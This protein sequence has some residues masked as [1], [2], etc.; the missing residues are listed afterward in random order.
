MKL[1]KILLISNAFLGTVSV[2]AMQNEE[3]IGCPT[4]KMVHPIPQPHPQPTWSP[5][6]NKVWAMEG[7]SKGINH[8]QNFIF[9]GSVDWIADPVIPVADKSIPAQLI[10]QPYQDKILLHCKYALYNKAYKGL[11]FNIEATVD[12]KNCVVDTARGVFKCTS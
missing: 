7:S 2:K 3:Y 1:L 11:Y 4:A 8:N 12:Y 5:L 9:K 6:G 10:V